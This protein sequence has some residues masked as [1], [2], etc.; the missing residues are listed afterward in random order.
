MMMMVMTIVINIIP[1]VI[2]I[3]KLQISVIAKVIAKKGKGQE[4]SRNPFLR[5]YELSV[6]NKPV[7]EGM[8]TSLIVYHYPSIQ[9]W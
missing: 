5:I 4:S 9:M 3:L 6:D 8:L 7:P 1:A 2:V